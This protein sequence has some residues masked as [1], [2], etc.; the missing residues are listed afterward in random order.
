M[1]LLTAPWVDIGSPPVRSTRG[2]RPGLDLC[3]QPVELQSVESR[4]FLAMERAF[5]VHGGMASGEEVARQ[6]R[7]RCDQPISM[8]ARWIV[9]RTVVSIAWRAQTLLPTFQFDRRDMSLRTPVVQAIAELRDVFDDWDLALWFAQPNAWLKDSS[10]VDL[11]AQDDTAV[12][13]AARADRFV[14]RG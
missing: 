6:L 12:L 1:N 2:P 8:L 14:A 10:P 5:S 3:R 13:Q 9:S 7:Q 11:L 4:Q